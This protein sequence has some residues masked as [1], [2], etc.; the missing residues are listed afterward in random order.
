MTPKVDIDQLLSLLRE[1]HCSQT[2]QRMLAEMVYSY[3]EHQKKIQNQINEERNR[4][5]R[6]IENCRE[7]KMGVLLSLVFLL[8]VAV[9]LTIAFGH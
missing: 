7:P 4:I 2:D 9:L 3:G 6:E 1:K 8:C 5:R